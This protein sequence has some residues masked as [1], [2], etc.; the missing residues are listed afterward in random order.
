MDVGLKRFVVTLDIAHSEFDQSTFIQYMKHSMSEVSVID[1]C[2]Y[3]AGASN[4]LT[5]SRLSGRRGSRPS[6]ITPEQ[7]VQSIKTKM[8]EEATKLIDVRKRLLER[9][10]KAL[11]RDCRL[12]RK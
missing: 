5:S 6:V 3:G 12:K 4:H 1:A 10:K 8:E 7:I 9:E 11:E 2:D